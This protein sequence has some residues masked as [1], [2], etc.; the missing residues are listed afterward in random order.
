MRQKTE[1][2]KVLRSDPREKTSAAF[3]VIESTPSVGRSSLSFRSSEKPAH[4]VS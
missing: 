4:E 2:M 3:D 1:M